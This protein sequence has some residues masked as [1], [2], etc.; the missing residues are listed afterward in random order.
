MTKRDYYEILE[1]SRTASLEEIKKA[2][3]RLAVKY[4]PDKNPD[5]K[6]AEESFKEVSE[7]YEVLWD[8]NKREVYDRFGHQG[9]QGRGAGFHDPFDIFREFFGSGFGG[10]IF[11][12]LFGFGGFTRQAQPRGADVDYELELDLE[13]AAFGIEKEIEIYRQEACSQCR[14]EGAEPGTGKKRCAH[15]GGSGQLRSSA[16]FL[17]ISRPCPRCR[18][19]GMVLE[20]PCRKCGGKGTEEK[21]R[22]VKV[23]IPSGVD[24]GSVLRKRGDG[25]AGFQKGPAGNLNIY[26]RIRP[27]EVFR[28]E[29]D[30]VYCEVPISFPLAAL[31]GEITVPTLDGQTTVKIPPGTQSGQFFRLRGEGIPRIQR[32]GRGDEHVQVTIETPTRL[33]DEQKELLKKLPVYFSSPHRDTPRSY[34]PTQIR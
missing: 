6:T 22:K 3:R 21:K 7:A 4:H 15:C 20:N 11:G 1:V 33:T 17:T 5:D 28:R 19:A 30:D 14:G 13:E 24:E 32:S 23:K 29:G 16:G 34:K 26:I 25:E 10:S 9:L 12:D 27:H 18:G 2:Y 8:P 31:G